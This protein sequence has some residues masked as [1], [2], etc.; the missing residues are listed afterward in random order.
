MTYVPALYRIDRRK[1]IDVFG[2]FFLG[3]YYYIFVYLFSSERSSMSQIK[4]LRIY[5]YVL[6][7][8]KISHRIKIVNFKLVCKYPVRICNVTS[9]IL[10]SNQRGDFHQVILNKT[11]FIGHFKIYINSQFQSASAHFY[12]LFSRNQPGRFPLG[13][14]KLEISNLISIF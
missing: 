14:S 5:T 8:R 1:D 4:V 9:K 12:R 7:P 3:S 13:N 2:M 10:N 6:W 11:K